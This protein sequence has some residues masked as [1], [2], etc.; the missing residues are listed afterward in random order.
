MR[1]CRNLLIVAAALAATT[2]LSARQV[3]DAPTYPSRKPGVTR[4][5]GTWEVVRAE[6]DGNAVPEQH[7]RGMRMVATDD[8]LT[9]FAPNGR[10]R[11]VARYSLNVTL[12][13]P[14]INMVLI[15][16]PNKDQK[17]QGIV[18]MEDHDTLKLCYS[19]G[20][21]GRPQ[22]FRTQTGGAVDLLIEMRR[23]KTPAEKQ[24]DAQREGEKGVPNKQQPV[25]PPAKSVPPKDGR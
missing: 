19:M 15:D 9:V 1:T 7:T 8:T 4:V 2:V 23:V 5:Q 17:A 24:A 6:K 22:E 18:D 3:P 25:P 20:T 12:K 14:A 10:P 21:Q 16:G 11:F 13:P